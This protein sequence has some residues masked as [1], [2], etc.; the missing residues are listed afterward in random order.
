[1]NPPCWQTLEGQSSKQLLET[2]PGHWKS[3]PEEEKTRSK[4]EKLWGGKKKEKK[5][6]TIVDVSEYLQGG[7]R[8]RHQRVC[9]GNRACHHPCETNDVI[10]NDWYQVG[11]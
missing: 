11:S 1:M 2:L 8:K 9:V 6:K 10:V 3:D 5:T 4:I 7:S